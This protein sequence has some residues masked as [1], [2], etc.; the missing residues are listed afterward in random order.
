MAIIGALPNNLQNGTTADASQV[1]ADLNFIVNQ[2][3]ANALPLQ[4][5]DTII[6]G[7]LT[8]NEQGST[9][10]T[11]VINAPSDPQGSVIKLVGNGVTT[12][13]K[14]LKAANG[15]FLITNTT[16]TAVLVQVTDAGNMAV[17][18]TVTGSNITASSDERLKKEWS[19]LP[20]NFIEM[21]AGVARGTFTRTDTGE[22]QAGV[23]AQS[24]LK[25]LK[26]AVVE[27]PDGMLSVAYGHAAL[28]TCIEL[29][30]EVVRLRA[31]LEPV[32]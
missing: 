32:K 4:P 10:G 6:N 3:N 12:P 24:L 30:A 16:D 31:L 23:S 28:V 8:L 15:S 21:M 14:F 17:T 5:G 9:D 1:M 19:A 26:E 25:V 22:R 13:T 11:L 27:G 7:T 2:V 20:E 18:G 29:C